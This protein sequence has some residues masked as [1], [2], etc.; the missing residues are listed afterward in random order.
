MGLPVCAKGAKLA[1]MDELYFF[2][3]QRSLDAGAF[4]S[5]LRT[6]LPLVT[7]DT[8]KLILADEL[9]AITEIG[10]ASKIIGSFIDMM[11]ETNSY[12]ILVSHMAP[13][14]HKYTDV[15]IDGIE[16]KG[17]DENYELVVD[18]TPC[19]NY[20]ARSTPEL[21]LRRLHAKS[22]GKMKEIYER[23]LGLFNEK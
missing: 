21:I 15:R 2:S 13:E 5:F 14:I 16:A 10:A 4:E 12:S 3:K 8:K 6:F 18:R 23:I 7:T 1:I 11:K 9:E 17:L 22:N 19:I 20:L